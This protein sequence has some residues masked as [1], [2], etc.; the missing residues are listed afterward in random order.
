MSG[1]NPSPPYIPKLRQTAS[2]LPVS[3][4]GDFGAILGDSWILSPFGVEVSKL[5]R[6]SVEETAL[7][8]S[9]SLQI[10][11]EEDGCPGGFPQLSGLRRW[12]SSL[13]CG[14]PPGVEETETQ[15]LEYQRIGRGVEISREKS[16]QDH[17]PSPRDTQSKLGLSWKP[18]KPPP[19]PLESRFSTGETPCQ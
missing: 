5:S 2:L 15:V 6:M 11:T 13:L 12:K 14:D 8:G 17:A 9:P 3:H 1:D 10:Q 19:R 16:L 7:G 18:R 4:L